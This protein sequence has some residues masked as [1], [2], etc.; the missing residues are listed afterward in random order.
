MMQAATGKREFKN[1]W[2]CYKQI[3]R[4]EGYSGLFKGNVSNMA[5]SIGSSLCLV[6]YDEIKKFFSKPKK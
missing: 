2:D 1:S 3:V 5:R 6:L 4:K